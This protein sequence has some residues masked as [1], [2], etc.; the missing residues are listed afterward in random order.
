MKTKNIETNAIESNALFYMI[1]CSN[2]IPKA[3]AIRIEYE[4]QSAVT[5]YNERFQDEKLFKLLSTS[6]EL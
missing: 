4:E 5:V 6:S 2:P 1:E 3:E